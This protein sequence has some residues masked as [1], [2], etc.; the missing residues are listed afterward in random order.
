MVHGVGFNSSKAV[1]WMPDIVV[2]G[3]DGSAVE[4][5]LGASELY[6]RDPRDPTYADIFPTRR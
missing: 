2:S 3:N 1:A 6:V 5:V 4:V